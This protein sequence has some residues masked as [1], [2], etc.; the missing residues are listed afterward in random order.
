MEGRNIGAVVDG[1]R[2]TV[3]SG[4]SEKSRVVPLGNVSRRRL[5][6]LID[7]IL[8]AW[9]RGENKN[10]GTGERCRRR[11]GGRSI[12]RRGGGREE[13]PRRRKISKRIQ[14]NI[15]FVFV[16]AMLGGR[17]S[18]CQVD[19]NGKND[20][21]DDA[22]GRALCV[23]GD[24][25]ERSGGEGDDGDDDRCLSDQLSFNFEGKFHERSWRQRGRM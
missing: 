9:K 16:D 22:D 13:C 12:F 21:A 14:N 3:V 24:C 4:E 7:I 1:K 18:Q 23:D 10:L 5:K 6:I 8:V 25:R 17:E 19:N 11:G 15:F 2:V 20:Q